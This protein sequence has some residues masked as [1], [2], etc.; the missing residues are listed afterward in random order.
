MRLVAG[1]DR[2]GADWTVQDMDHP[3]AFAAPAA[4]E[5]R[6]FWPGE[7]WPEVQAMIEF[8]RERR[9]LGLPSLEDAPCH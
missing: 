3:Q 9:R 6:V 5:P 7:L 4:D 1:M 8:D 2:N